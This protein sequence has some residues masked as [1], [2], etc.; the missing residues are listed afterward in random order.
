MC[1]RT[2]PDT[3]A[4]AVPETIPASAS[5]FKA[6]FEANLAVMYLLDPR[7]GVIQDANP[8]ASAFYGI[9]RE[10]LVGLPIAALS[11]LSLRR[12]KSILAGIRKSGGGHVLSRHRLKTGELR[13]VEI[14]STLLTLPGGRESVFTIVHDITGRIRAE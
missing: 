3:P 6:A 1:P 13:D 4:A 5:V 2:K 11:T 12:I 9:P 14:H 10:E 8:A 7:T